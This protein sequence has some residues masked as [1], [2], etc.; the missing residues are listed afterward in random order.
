MI[1]LKWVCLC[2]F[3][4]QSIWTF[5][6]CGASCYRYELPGH[7]TVA[8]ATIT[9]DSEDFIFQ[10][11]RTPSHFHFDVHAHLSANLPGRLLTWPSRLPDLTSC[12]FLLWGYI[13]DHVYVPPIP[14]DLPLLRQ[15]IVKAVVAID[16]Q[17]LHCVWHE[18]DYKVDICCVTKGGHI[19]HL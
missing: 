4:L 5:F 7:A 17:M 6:L 3:L 9:G 18:F 14:R 19:E 10:Q 12:D 1:C 2:H 11:D 16:S 15:R 8:N 13:K